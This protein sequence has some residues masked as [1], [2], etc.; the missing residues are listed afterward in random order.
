MLSHD[1]SR[2]IV[3]RI[4]E[5]NTNYSIVSFLIYLLSVFSSSLFSLLALL[6]IVLRRMGPHHVSLEMI[7]SIALVVTFSTGKG[8]LPSVCA[9]V[10]F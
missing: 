2:E 8:L 9:C 4:K 1:E 6:L 5:R 10:L 3:S 7:R